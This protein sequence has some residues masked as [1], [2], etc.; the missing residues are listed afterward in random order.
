MDDSLLM[1]LHAKVLE[2]FHNRCGLCFRYTLVV[3]EIEPRS[4][5]KRAIR[6]ENM[7]PLCTQCH[8]SVHKNGAIVME[9]T[10]LE[11]R[12]ELETLFGRPREDK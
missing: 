12:Q 4:S 7:I 11:A 10:L 9:K 6:E 5:G 3:H 8:D 1:S 2:R